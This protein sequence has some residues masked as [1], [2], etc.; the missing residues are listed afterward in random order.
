MKKQKNDSPKYFSKKYESK[1]MYVPHCVPSWYS[2]FQLP[3]KRPHKGILTPWYATLVIRRKKR[4]RE[5]ILVSCLFTKHSAVCLQFFVYL[6]LEEEF[7]VTVEQA[8]PFPCLWVEA[9]GVG[10]GITDNP[11]SDWVVGIPSPETLCPR[12]WID[13]WKYW[14]NIF[15]IKSI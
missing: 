9:V 4:R 6:G 11:R 8:M 12:I 3:L 14:K 2:I 5:I 15:L 7:V 13:A 1:F 10:Q